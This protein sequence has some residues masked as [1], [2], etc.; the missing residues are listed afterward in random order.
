MKGRER[1]REEK[2]FRLVAKRAYSSVE[3]TSLPVLYHFFFFYFFFFTEDLDALERIS[4]ERES[5]R[6]KYDAKRERILRFSHSFAVAAALAICSKKDTRAAAYILCVYIYLYKI[7]IYVTYVCVCVSCGSSNVAIGRVIAVYAVA[8]LLV[9][10]HHIAILS[11]LGQKKKFQEK[12]G[13]EREMRK[14][15]RAVIRSRLR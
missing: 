9:L 10:T 12:E 1:K 14:R 8:Q 15:E 11:G 13:R 4:R 6:R 7:Y 5:D 2:G 3:K